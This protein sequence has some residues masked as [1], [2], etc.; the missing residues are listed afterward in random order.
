MRKVIKKIVANELSFYCGN[1]SKLHFRQMGNGREILLI[2]A[3]A[4]FIHAIYKK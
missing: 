2:D 3:V 4:T 1:Y